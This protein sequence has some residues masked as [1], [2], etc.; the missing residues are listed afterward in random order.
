MHGFARSKP[1]MF[2][3]FTTFYSVER[4]VC[5]RA[6]KSEH[7]PPR[8]GCGAPKEQSSLLTY[9]PT[10]MHN[11]ARSRR[12]VFAFF[13]AF[14]SV[15]R[16]VCSRASKSEQLLP[17][18]QGAHERAKASTSRAGKLLPGR[19]SFKI[20]KLIIINLIIILN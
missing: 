16:D 8:V 4:D 9:P 14:Y 7:T 17:G 13:T 11:P 15:E 12:A 19:Q 10:S 3:F 18:R 6:S 1:D 2:A 20:F 5:S